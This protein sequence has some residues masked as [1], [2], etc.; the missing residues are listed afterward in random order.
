MTCNLPL[1]PSRF[2][3]AV[4]IP[5]SS[6][7]DA[8]FTTHPHRASVH[9]RWTTCRLSEPDIILQCQPRKATNHRR[10]DVLPRIRDAKPVSPLEVGLAMA[11]QECPLANRV[12]RC[13]HDQIPSAGHHW[14]QHGRSA[15]HYASLAHAMF[16]TVPLPPK[17]AG[18]LACHL[19]VLKGC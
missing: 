14:C 5:P 13:Y 11:T 17:S 10:E 18:V 8:L 12:C 9:T 3:P 6:N 15:L 4:C 19:V 1:P 7:V 2:R 16:E